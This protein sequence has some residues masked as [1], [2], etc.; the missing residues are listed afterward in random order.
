MCLAFRI[1]NGKA[2]LSTPLACKCIRSD[3]DSSK[4]ISNEIS[5]L[6]LIHGSEYVIKHVRTFKTKSDRYYM[7]MELCNGGDLAL[8]KEARGGYLREEEARVVLAKVVKGLALLNK[9]GCVH[10]DIKLSNVLLHFNGPVD[11]KVYTDFDLI[12]MSATEKK[13]FLS[14]VDLLKTDF[15]VKLADFGFSKI[16]ASSSQRC[17]LMCGTPYYMSPQIVDNESYSAKTDVWSFGVLFFELISGTVPFKGSNF[18]QLARNLHLGTYQLN[19]K[20]RPSTECIDVIGRCLKNK[21]EERI[22]VRELAKLGYWQSGV[23]P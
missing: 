23:T 18:P 15:R 22:S 1:V 7:F 9:H 14:R 11:G 10:R 17:N 6:A 3:E 5:S 19:L 12:S 13:A 4:Q 16:L 20:H 21:E 2:D 8:L